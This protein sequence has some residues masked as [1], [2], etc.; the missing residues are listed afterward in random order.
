MK[1][2]VKS[3]LK[4]IRRERT[5]TKILS[6]ALCLVMVFYV[7]PS[8]IYTKAAELLENE[9]G[10]E[11]APLTN[12]DSEQSEVETN[13]GVLFEDV[14][15]RE[16]SAKHFHLEDGRYVAAQYNYPVHILDQN[17]E[18]QDIDNALVES[19]SEFTNSNAR[20]KFAKKINGSSELFALHDGNTKLTLTLIDAVKGTVGEITNL[21]DTE[22][23]TELQK[24]MNLEKLSAS[25]IYRDILDGVDLEYVAYSMNVKENI[26]VKEKKE[27]YSYSFEL[28]LNGLTPT[29]TE[30]GDIEIRSDGTNGLTYIIPAPVVFDSEGAYAP[31]DRAYYSLTHKNGKKYT[32]TVTVDSVWMNAEERAFPVTVDPAVATPSATVIDTY[33]DSSDDMLSGTTDTV[34]YVTDTRWSYWRYASLPTLSASANILE[35]NITVTATENVTSGSYVGVHEVHTLWDPGHNTYTHV[36]YGD[37][38]FYTTPLDYCIINGGGAYTF[39]VTKIV[40]SWYDV[41]NYGLVFHKVSG[42]TSNVT[43]HSSESSSLSARPSLTVIYKDMKGIESYW[44][45]SSHNAGVAGSGSVNLANGN[46]VFTIPTVTATDSIFSYTPTLVYDSSMSAKY[47]YDDTANIGITNPF[48][49]YGFKLSLNETLRYYSTGDGDFYYVHSDPD[50]TEHMFYASDDGTYRDEDG[51][52]QT[53]TVQSDGDITIVDASKTVKL[54][55]RVSHA[56]FGTRWRLSYVEDING[57]RLVFTY[58]SVYYNLFK[59]LKIS[60][61]P[62]GYTTKIDLL[63]LRYKNNGK[64]GMIY[65]PASRQAAVLR[66][67]NTYN[68]ETL[69]NGY[70]YLRQIDYAYGNSSVTTENWNAFIDDESALTNIS[71]YDSAE[72]SYNSQGYIIEAKTKSTS[73]SVKY[74]WGN[75]N[76]NKVSEYVGNTRGQE[77][78]FKY[79]VCFAETRAT[80]NDEKIN[81]MD[82]ILTR[83][84]LD[85]H[86]RAI[87]V[88]SCSVDGRTIYGATSGAYDDESNM[89][90]LKHKAVLGGS[91]INHLLNGDFE[92]LDENNKFLHWNETS[93][94]YRGNAYPECDEG[95]GTAS[96]RPTSTIDASISQTVF[97]T[98]GSYTLSML[99][100]SRFCENYD[101][102]VTINS[103]AGSGFT[104]TESFSLNKDSTSIKKVAFS[105]SFE[106][107]NFTG[108]GDYLEIRITLGCSLIN[109]SVLFKI[110][111]VML[112]DSLGSSNYSLVSYGGFEET[113]RGSTNSIVS[114][115]D[116]WTLGDE[117]DPLVLYISD[118]SNRAGEK[119]AKVDKTDHYVKQRIY[120]INESDLIYYGTQDFYGNAYYDYI[121]SGFG[122]AEFAMV[123]DNSHFRIRVDVYY[124][125]GEGENEVV[126]SHYFDFLPGIDG[127]QFI[128]G[129]FST[130]YT[131]PDDSGDTNKYNC[132]SA[133]DIYC[134]YSNQINGY[135]LFENISVVYADLDNYISYK[136]YTDGILKGKLASK[137]NPDYIEYYSYDSNANLSVVATSRADL[138]KYE[139][140]NKNQLISVINCEYSYNGKFELPI[141]QADPYALVSKYYKNK[142]EYDYDDYGN[143][144]Q[145]TT[146]PLDHDDG[147]VIS[148]A[149]KI[150]STYTYIT[151]TIPSMFGALKTET[152]STG[153]TTEY[154]YNASTCRL[155]ATI[156]T[157]TRNGFSYNYDSKGRLISVLPA[158][159][160][161]ASTFLKITNAEKVEYTYGS[162]NTLEGISTNS[163]DYAFSY[164]E[165]GNRTS[166]EV[167]DNTLASYEYADNNGKLKKVTYGNGFVVEY[168]YNA[169]ENLS[170]IW[171]TDSEGIRTKAYEYEYTADGLIHSV[172][173]NLNGRQTVY[174]Y[175]NKNRLSKIVSSSDDDMYNDLFSY[176]VFYD[177]GKLHYISTY[178]DLVDGTNYD[179]TDYDNTYLSYF[180]SY[181]SEGNQLSLYNIVSNYVQGGLV[182][183]YDALYRLSNEKFVLKS[184]DASYTYTYKDNGQYTTGQIQSVT[185]VINE[186]TTKSETY[187]YDG[188]GNI[189]RIT[190]AEGIYTSYTYD[191]LGQLTGE[192]STV[193]GKGYT[194]T[195]D[196]AG[197]LTG[198]T[199]TVNSTGTSSVIKTYGYTDSEWGDLLTSFNGT[200]I[201]Y[202]AIGNPLSYYNGENYTFTWDGR[203]LATAVKGSNNMSFIYDDE[204]LRISKTVNSVT[205][206]YYYQGSL[207]YAEETNSQITVYIYDE[208]GAPIGFMYRGA[209]YDNGVWDIYAFEKNIQGDVVAVYNASTGAKLISYKYNAWGECTTAY[210]NGGASTTAIKNPYK[211]RGYYYD[212]DLG[213]YYL[214]TRYY[215]ANICRFINADS[216]LYHSMLGYNMFAYCENNP[217]NYYDPTGK[218]GEAIQYMPLY[219]AW[220]P[221]VDGG[222]PIADLLYLGMVAYVT[223]L[224]LQAKA[225]S[226]P[227][228]ADDPPKSLTEP[229][230]SLGE[231][232]TNAK[233]DNENKDSRFKGEPGEIIKTG[234]KETHIG[235]NGLADKERHW[236]DHGN[237]KH[238]TIP[239]DHDIGWNEDGKI[240]WGDKHNYWDDNIPIFP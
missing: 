42:Y 184:F 153:A 157:G 73:T 231:I 22:S 49:P 6:F 181:N 32:L 124:Y 168:V 149:N 222:L 164:D 98:A 208:N 36:T 232:P 107:S 94:V 235:D 67:S 31:S 29:L 80:G 117:D 57:N 155:D 74:T 20:I 44:P 118:I 185:T 189:T 52:G 95:Y 173:D 114:I 197:N 8:T 210:Y 150:K 81:T 143:I 139:Y 218:N 65:S 221:L 125:Q 76:V 111:N 69:S 190:Y 147:N 237:P 102:Y 19:G 84:T 5:L 135:A 72:Y 177:D 96:F 108:G 123:S 175:D 195:Y 225:L 90:S 30:S 122:N 219:M 9:D 17:G 138:V 154:Y 79:D 144:V 24:M 91:A 12:I 3:I 224:A 103:T 160:L 217:V 165:F 51:L 109:N 140:N 62:N 159:T 188:E 229:E 183:T 126:R 233:N 200:A 121:V 166:V 236:T 82:D 163:T 170:E 86:G 60:L 18:W 40:K 14:S 212:S 64:L 120:Q 186:S 59:P 196:T 230:D 97:L 104:H 179:N 194:Y 75:Y 35:A 211:Y 54:F 21:T 226:E 99:Y 25:V 1:E 113:S 26:I 171:Y 85:M 28:K 216:A 130:K 199:R 50:G 47:Y 182:F 43:F 228:I 27:S 156:N 61:L 214:Q 93:N 167:G 176:R 193:D 38:S 240:V 146:S 169:L 110:D 238:H 23:D 119:A 4:F 227:E 45:Y 223:V 234:D 191:K 41:F 78:T 174:T 2:R 37:G 142:T 128:S 92:E 46:L 101:G 209:D 162:D 115:N 161:P 13:N 58:D 201:T 145:I 192:S 152:D 133:I 129:S 213:L 100:V 112:C 33:V 55:D 87:S 178:I 220:L 136:Y 16:E 151:V 172:K 148:E 132:V 68:G 53:L 48:L 88:Y 137:E 215:D 134:E 206:N 207:L 127:W 56:D 239:H 180:Y 77:L 83:Y 141:E 131:P 34:L 203:R 15:L 187:N 116:Y 10:A 7:I 11:A 106:V 66:Y 204:G 158:Y 70:A 205:T 71:V 89:N 63:E 39:D 105:T 202:D 198:V